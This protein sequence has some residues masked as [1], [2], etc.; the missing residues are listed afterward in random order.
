MQWKVQR[1]IQRQSSR[2][3]VALVILLLILAVALIGLLQN[4]PWQNIPSFGEEDILI[5][6]I[7]QN[8]PEVLLSDLLAQHKVLII[9]GPKASDSAIFVRLSDGVSVLFSSQKNIGQQVA[10]L[11][12]ILDRITIEGKKAAAIDFRYDAPIVRYQK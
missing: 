5:A 10:S 4:V 3:K 7:P 11:Q 2:L 6:P 12:I 8:E 1:Q 9:D